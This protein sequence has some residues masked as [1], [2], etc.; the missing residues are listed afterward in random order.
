MFKDAAEKRTTLICTGN[1][2]GIHALRLVDTKMLP[3]AG[4]QFRNHPFN[5][6]RPRELSNGQKKFESG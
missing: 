5:P 4:L 1:R 2:F 6:K 3:L